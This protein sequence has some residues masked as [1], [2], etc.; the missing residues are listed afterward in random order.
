MRLREAV[1]RQGVYPQSA[2]VLYG[3][4]AEIPGDVEEGVEGRGVFALLAEKGVGRVLVGE[5]S[6]GE[7]VGGVGPRHLQRGH[8]DISGCAGFRTGEG[9][10]EG[11]GAV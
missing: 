10:G 4:G 3:P 2:I 11:D 9:G 5:G 6:V 1:F 7:H 8:Q